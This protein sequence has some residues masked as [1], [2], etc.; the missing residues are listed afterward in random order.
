[1]LNIQLDE[2]EVIAILDA[3]GNQIADLEDTIKWMGD[4]EEVPVL[5]D[6]V[7]FLSELDM[8]IREQ[9]FRGDD[10]MVGRTFSVAEDDFIKMGA[11]AREQAKLN[12]K[13]MMG[14]QSGV[15]V[16]TLHGLED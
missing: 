14:T 3:V 12:S 11:N 6:R 1:M 9:A 10:G 8:D 13:L 2:E 16:W 5:R 7:Q 15:D 4:D